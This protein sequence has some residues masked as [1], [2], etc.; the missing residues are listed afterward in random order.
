MGMEPAVPL[1]FGMGTVSLLSMAM[2]V[3]DVK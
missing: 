2:I 3:L 1:G